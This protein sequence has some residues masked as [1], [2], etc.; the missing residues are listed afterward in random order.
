MRS[1]ELNFIN[2]FSYLILKFLKSLIL[3]QKTTTFDSVSTERYHIEQLEQ[4]EIHW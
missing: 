4:E 3:S 2:S 1:V